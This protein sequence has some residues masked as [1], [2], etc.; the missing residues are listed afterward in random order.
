MAFTR[1]NDA[2]EIR[3]EDYAW[4]MD[5]YILSASVAVTQITPAP[6]LS[7]L[8]QEDPAGHEIRF[9]LT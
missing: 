3:F 6:A 7:E 9:S 8:H 1:K 5:G 4:G 2:I